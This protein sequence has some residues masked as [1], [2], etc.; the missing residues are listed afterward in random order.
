MDNSIVTICLIPECESRNTTFEPQWLQN[1]IPYDKDNF[2]NCVRYSSNETSSTYN[3]NNSCPSSFFNYNQLEGCESWIYEND[4]TIVSEFDL[5]CQSWKQT[6]VGTINNVGQFVCMPLSGIISDRFGRRTIL[7]AGITI[8]GIVGLAKSFAPNYWSFILFEFLDPALGSG[9]YAAGFILAVEL[10]GPQQRVLGSTIVSGFY[11]V[12]EIIMG[13]VALLSPYWRTLLRIIYSP[14]ILLICYFWL[15]PESVRWLVS[16]GKS[17]E[18]GRQLLRAA[19]IN[20]VTLSSKSLEV[21]NVSS[22]EHLPSE[23]VITKSPLLQI[24]RSPTLMVRLIC[25]S[26][27][28][29]TCTFTYYGLSLNSVSLSGNIYVNFIL[30]SLVEIPGYITYYFTVDRFGRKICLSIA[31]LGSGISCIAFAF[32]PADI[33]GLKIFLYLFGKFCITIAFTVVYVYTTELFPTQLRHSLL[34]T[35][36]MFGRMGSIVAPQTPLLSVYMESLPLI[37][38]GGTSI[39]SGCMVLFFPET[40]NTKLP[41][42]IEEA[43]NISKSKNDR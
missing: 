38:F 10:V 15:I 41:D 22:S 2:D 18:A 16:K 19:Q 36:S 17:E 31:F 1:A 12:G 40:L 32:V 42:T 34:G 28:W 24:L 11:A 26:F 13:V 7:I 37:L 4:N 9:A 33:N 21:L 23:E 8:S 14:A 5:A 39:V 27:W 3:F 29:I 30:V 20:K 6:L 25:C 35:C 43:E